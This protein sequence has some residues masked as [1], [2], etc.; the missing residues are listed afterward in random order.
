MRPT[1]R[2][3]YT[4][5]NPIEVVNPRYR[6]IGPGELRYARTQ[7]DYK[8]IV[9]CGHCLTCR[10]RRARMWHFRLYHE[11][12]ACSTHTFT[13]KKGKHVDS[14]RVLFVTFTFNDDNLPNVKKNKEEREILAPYIR[15]WRDGWRKKFGIS[16][17]YFAISDVGGDNGRLHLHLLIFDP[18]DKYGRAISKSSI[19]TYNRDSSLVLPPWEQCGWRYGYCTYA[20]WLRGLEGIHY[21]AGYINLQ[22]ALKEAERGRGMRKHGK[23]LCKAARLH[24]ASIFCSPGLGRSW[25]NTSEF[26]SC[27]KT[28]AAIA[29]VGKYRYAIPRYYKLRYFE[30]IP[31]GYGA[32]WTREE[33]LSAFNAKYIRSVMKEQR[34]PQV[35]QGP[36][37]TFT[38]YEQLAAYRKKMCRLYLDPSFEYVISPPPSMPEYIEDGCYFEHMDLLR[39]RQLVLRG[40]KNLHFVVKGA[41]PRRIKHRN[42]TQPQ[43]LF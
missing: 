1:Q 27:K 20:G 43:K 21:V 31:L 28:R 40:R 17:R 18:R 36:T 14:P 6:K 24:F 13:D 32:Y 4:C 30:P 26:A 25:C 39:P 10:Q 2:H 23:S 9:P 41:P 34:G 15:K 7:S 22:N 35:I 33:Q 42:K 29:S 16:P 3:N 37:Q 5:D 8:L 38:N 19:Y 11:A 12:L